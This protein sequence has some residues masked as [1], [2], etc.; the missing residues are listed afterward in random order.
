MEHQGGLSRAFAIFQVILQ[1]GG[2]S[3]AGPED[4]T[5]GGGGEGANRGQAGEEKLPWQGEEFRR[6][7]NRDQ[8]VRVCAII[9]RKERTL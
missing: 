8:M 1:M 4:W 9:R 5:L 6:I 3:G 2:G 7:K